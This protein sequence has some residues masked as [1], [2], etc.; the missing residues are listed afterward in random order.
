MLLA[1]GI[2]MAYA[3]SVTVNGVT[4]YYIT[5]T[6]GDKTCTITHQGST[7]TEGSSYYN[8]YT[9]TSYEIPTTL[10]GYTVTQL[11]ANA[12]RGC[13]NIQSVTFASGT[14]VKVIGN[15]CFRDCSALIKIEL[16]TTVTKLGDRAFS[17]T[18]KMPTFTVPASVTEMAQNPFDGMKE[19][20]EIVLAEG[21]TAFKIIDGVLYDKDVKRLIQMPARCGMK[22]FKMPSTVTTVEHSSIQYNATLLSVTASENL[23]AL[24]SYFVEKSYRLRWIDLTPCKSLTIENLTRVSGSGTLPFYGAPTHALVYLPSTCTLTADN[25]INTNATPYTCAKLVLVDKACDNA[26]KNLNDTM[27]VNAPYYGFEVP[28]EFTATEGTLTRSLAL[29]AGQKTMVCL[30]FALT[31][32]EAT[33]LGKFYAFNTIDTKS[34]T[35]KLTATTN[36]T[37]AYVPYVIEPTGTAITFSNKTISK[38]PTSLHANHEGAD[39]EENIEDGLVGTFI[40]EGVASGSAE[41]FYAYAGASEGSGDEAVSAGQFVRLTKTAFTRPF[42]GYLRVASSESS[43][44]RAITAYFYDIDGDLETT[45]LLN[46]ETGD[47]E[48]VSADWYTMNG[49]RLSGRPSAKGIYVNNGKKYVVK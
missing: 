30:P 2:V 10:N 9:A 15:S 49:V 21:N 47:V 44:N 35:M 31:A 39:Y 23:T 34:S 1:A 14:A 26:G 48:P 29:T 40:T 22:H 3:E 27:N 42:R 7:T 8:T 46:V 18:H 41:S 25:C 5:N 32:D 45:G 6:D 20:R 24:N 16:P 28:Y 19:L 4:W 11:G 13:K 36:G 43:A 38:T 33:T 12:F 37:K 17:Q